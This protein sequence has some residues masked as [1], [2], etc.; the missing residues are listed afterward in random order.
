MPFSF[1]SI[2][3]IPFCPPKTEGFAAADVGRRENRLL[4]LPRHVGGY[5]QLTPIQQTVF[6]AVWR[7]TFD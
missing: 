5:D 3:E 6:L 4:R 7:P 1:H 2:K